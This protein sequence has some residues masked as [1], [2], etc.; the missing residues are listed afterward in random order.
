MWHLLTPTV[1]AY[2][3]N[4]ITIPGNNLRMWLDATDIDGDNNNLNNPGDGTPVSLWVD[5][6]GNV[7]NAEQANPTYYPLYTTNSLNNLPTVTFGGEM[8]LHH[9]SA[10]VSA[11]WNFLHNSNPSTVFVVG[12]SLINDT[13]TDF[14]LSTGGATAT[15]VGYSFFNQISPTRFGTYTSN[16]TGGFPINNYLNSSDADYHM[17]SLLYKSTSPVFEYFKDGTLVSTQTNTLATPSSGNASFPLTLGMAPDNASRALAGDLA[18][19]IIFDRDLNSSEKTDVECYLSQKWNLSLPS[20]DTTPPVLINF[21][22]SSA[23][24]TYQS[25]EF[26]NITAT[27][28]ENILLSSMMTVILDTGASVTLDTVSGST[29]SGVYNPEIAHVTNDLN[30][31]SIHSSLVQDF[32]N[33]ISTMTILPG[34][35]NNIADTKNILIQTTLPTVP[36]I[37]LAGQSNALGRAALGSISRTDGTPNSF[38]YDGGIVTTNFETLQQ[39]VNQNWQ[40]PGSEFG[41]EMGIAYAHKD[42]GTQPIYLIKYAFGSTNLASVPGNDWNSSSTNEYFENL[43]SEVIP[44]AFN[45][46]IGLGYTPDIRGVLWMQGENDGTS[47]VYATSYETN[48]EDFINKIRTKTNRSSLPFIIGEVRTMPTAPFATTVRAAQASVA[49]TVANTCLL[50]TD[51]LVLFDSIHFNAASTMLLGKRFW[52]ALKDC[53]VDQPLLTNKQINASTITLTYNELLNTDSIPLIENY[54][55]LVNGS[56]KIPSTISLNTNKVIITLPSSVTS[57]NTVVLSY[58]IPE[59]NPLQDWSINI[60]SAISSVNLDNTTPTSVHHSGGGGGG[61]KKIYPLVVQENPKIQLVENLETPPIYCEPLLNSFLKY[62]MRNNAAVKILQE[63]LKK[64]IDPNQN[65][66]GNFFNQTLKNVHLFQ[67]KYSKDI[68]EPVNAK[69]STGYVYTYTLKKINDLNCQK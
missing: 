36:V 46:L 37:I 52:N 19:V 64:N 16:G 49:D 47:S 41:P 45:N 26:I 29:V 5:K 15:S 10:G 12:R 57:S 6:S 65:I 56:I 4:P 20:C 62:G 24:G 43:T 2:I 34:P 3:T 27:F 51:D 66:T 23:D 22:S 53:D 17:H 60:A 58:A 44:D 35:P 1:H 9:M 39:G 28:S 7:K 54:T 33:N 18:E 13:S 42:E 25:G 50:D 31:T 67:L 59:I 48:L 14:F 61:G 55:I 63:F 32:S 69:S 8:V 68:L 30:I 21:T 38:I 11:D 40:N